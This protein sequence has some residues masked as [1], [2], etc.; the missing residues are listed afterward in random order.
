MTG[1]VDFRTVLLDE[2]G[3]P[4]DGENPLPTTDGNLA[5]AYA[6]NDFIDG[7][8]QYIG[9]AKADGTWLVQR[10][11]TASGQMRYANVSNNAGL[12]YATAWSQRTT[13]N[14]VVFQ[15]LTGV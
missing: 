12:N 13:L 3:A 8:P 5:N 10:F 2:A 14:Y 11:S 7:D 4:I 9:K 6:L 15:T 1:I